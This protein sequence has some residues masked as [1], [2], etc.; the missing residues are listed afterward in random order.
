MVLNDERERHWRMVL[1]DKNG[2]VEGKKSLHYANRWDV[3]NSEKEALIKD[4]YSVG[5]TE[6]YR[7]KVIW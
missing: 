7:K 5:V 4:G 1:E 2:R 6:K 3:Y